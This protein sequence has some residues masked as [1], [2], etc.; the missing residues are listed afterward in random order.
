MLCIFLLIYWKA[1]RRPPLDFLVVFSHFH[2]VNLNLSMQPVLLLLWP[3]SI[4]CF[5]L[6]SLIL[7]IGWVNQIY[8]R[9]K[10]HF[11]FYCV[12]MGCSSIIITIIWSQGK[13]ILLYIVHASLRAWM[14]RESW[15]IRVTSHSRADWKHTQKLHL[16]PPHVQPLHPL[17]TQQHFL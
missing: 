9:D 12:F 13:S 7:F 17:P 14:K 4:M 3:F 5:E 10:S 11:M 15:E 8:P 16:P 2:L 1:L 6:I